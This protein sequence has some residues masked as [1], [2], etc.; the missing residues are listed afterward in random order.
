MLLWVPEPIHRWAILPRWFS[1][2]YFSMKEN[3]WH[4]C[5]SLSFRWLKYECLELSSTIFSQHL[6][7]LSPI[8]AY[9]SSAVP[10]WFLPHL[11]LFIWVGGICAFPSWSR[12]FPACAVPHSSIPMGRG[13]NNT[14]VCL[15]CCK[16]IGLPFR[17]FFFVILK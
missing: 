5:S 17:F 10:K 13:S 6:W 16:L 11:L 15:Q 14:L 1:L 4:I 3:I 8:A 9:C 2:A 7:K 12:Q